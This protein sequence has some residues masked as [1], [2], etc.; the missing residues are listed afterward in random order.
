MEPQLWC[1][2]CGAQTRPG[3]FFCSNCGNNLLSAPPSSKPPLPVMERPILPNSPDR[4]PAHHGEQAMGRK[5]WGIGGTCLMTM[6]LLLG[7]LSLLG[8]LGVLIVRGGNWSLGLIVLP[9]GI[10]LAMYNYRTALPDRKRA[11]TLFRLL[12]IM[13]ILLGLLGL[14]AGISKIGGSW[15][16][17]MFLPL[18][19]NFPIVNW[20][21]RD[22]SAS[23]S[24]RQAFYRRQEQRLQRVMHYVG[25][26]GV[27]S[28]PVY[29]QLTDVP[30]EMAR[31]DLEVLVRRGALRATGNSQTG[32]YWFP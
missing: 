29:C 10:G 26:H 6:A 8:L 4:G 12:E 7:G 14:L 28:I 23:F 21:L 32:Q 3:E 18:L 19:I 24:S 15:S 11:R 1:P 27:I 31:S 30:E 9:L 5:L 16:L 17:L 20:R 22:T 2:S 25:E 13:L